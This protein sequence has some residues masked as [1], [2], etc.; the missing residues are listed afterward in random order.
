VAAKQ[1][2]SACS[3][4][5]TGTG[6]AAPTYDRRGRTTIALPSP[7]APRSY[8][9]DGEAEAGRSLLLGPAVS[10]HGV[11]DRLGFLQRQSPCNAP[12]KVQKTPGA[13]LATAHMQRAPPPAKARSVRAALPQFSTVSCSTPSAVRHPVHQPFFA[14]TFYCYLFV[15]FYHTNTTIC[16]GKSPKIIY[17]PEGSAFL[18]SS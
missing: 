16:G 10:G 5:R 12:G 13:A 1:R 7:T 3:L 6:I 17:R 8:R 15:F 2:A 14:S 4:S 11:R 18:S 9:R